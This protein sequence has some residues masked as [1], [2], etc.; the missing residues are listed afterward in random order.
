MDISQCT[1]TNV[2]KLNVVK[3]ALHKDPSSKRKVSSIKLN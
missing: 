2:I 3:K 1:V